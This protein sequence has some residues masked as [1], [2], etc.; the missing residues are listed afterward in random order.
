MSATAAGIGEKS[1]DFCCMCGDEWAD[2]KTGWILCDSYGCENTVCSTCTTTLSLSVSELFYC[3]LCSGSGTSAAAAA[4]GAVASAVAAC[5]SLEALPLSFKT[6]QKILTNLLNKPDE[7]KYRKLRMEN[8]SVKQLV[9]LEP[10]LNILIY[11]GF[12]RTQ[13]ARQIKTK[14]QG[15]T[16]VDANLPPTE[17]V[18]LLEGQVPINQV[19]EL[20]DIMNGLSQ[21]DEENENNYTT[22]K[23]GTS[24][25]I[26]DSGIT[27]EKRKRPSLPDESEANKKQKSED[28]EKENEK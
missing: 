23:D 3:P 18:L 20:L 25:K 1:S 17:D 9:D 8:K 16:N 26:D 2:G 11:I 24:G 15:E 22:A 14:K 28:L 21:Q 10:V 4:G 5:S 19:K 27:T 6:T 12:V 7:Q 13:C